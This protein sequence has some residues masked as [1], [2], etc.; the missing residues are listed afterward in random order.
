M[1]LIGLAG[2]KQAGKNT[3]AK[4]IAE[5]RPDLKIEERGFADLLKWSAYRIFKPDCTRE[6]AIEWA[7]K[8]KFIGNLYMSTDGD[9]PLCAVTGRETLQRYGTEAHREIFADNFWVD[10]LLPTDPVNDWTTKFPGAD[11]VLITD[12]RFENEAERISALGGVVVEVCRPGGDE[13]D[14]HASE[15]PLPGWMID[16]AMNNQGSIDDLRENV[17]SLL[18]WVDV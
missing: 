14:T 16:Y 12:V 17:K 13:S 15:K 9:E 7:D 1:I 6:E 2:R 8:F 3:T 18:H 4:L 11:I 5:L 10:A